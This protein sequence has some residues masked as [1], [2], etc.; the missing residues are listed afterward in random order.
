M[1]SDAPA[2]PADGTYALWVDQFDTP[3][4]VKRKA[5]RDRLAELGQEPLISV[6]MPV[7]NPSPEFL[8][9]AI[10]S[11]RGQLYS[12][13][14]LCIADDL[15]SEAHVDEILAEYEAMDSR[16]K[17][18]RRDANGH[19]SAASNSAL[20]TATGAWVGCL[21]HDDILAEQA[22]ALVAITLSDHPRAG[23]VYSDEDKLDASGQRHGPYFK[24]DYDP[25]D[26]RLCI[27]S[28]GDLFSALSSGVASIITCCSL[29]SSNR[30]YARRGEVLGRALK[31]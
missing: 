27:A 15:S 14:E 16:I 8:R 2:H 3:N 24:P 1:P 21:D 28:D 26:Q 31:R 18:T 13:W 20:S 11:V 6:I 17:V 10:D 19:I 30:D 12:N 22:L 9:S 23:I 29:W 5:I 25:W 7:Y 4:D